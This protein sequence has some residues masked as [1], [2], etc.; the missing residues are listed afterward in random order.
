[1]GST[2]ALRGSLAAGRADAYSV[3]DVR[4]VVPDAGVATAVG[5][6]RTVLAAVRPVES[7]RSDPLFQCSRRHRFLFVRFA[8]VPLFWRLDLEVFAESAQ[9]DPNCDLDNAV[10]SGTEWSLAESALANAVAAIKATLRQRQVVADELLARAFQRLE[11]SMPPGDQALRVAALAEAARLADRFVTELAV[12]VQRLVRRRHG[13]VEDRMARVALCM[14]RV[15]SERAGNL[16]TLVA[17]PREAADKG[18]ALVRFAETALTGLGATGDPAHDLLLGEPV[19]CPTTTALAEVARACR[20]WIGLGLYERADHRLY[21]AAVLL[22]PAGVAALHYCRIDPHWHRPRNDP[23]V[24]PKGNAVPVAVTP[25]G[26]CAFLLC[27][28]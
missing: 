4:W 11:T 19:P 18:V 8:G 20:I 2:T 12:R 28:D 24:Y 9:Q 7:L 13:N 14:H 15:Q 26:R 23:T 1:M 10:A 17:M 21:D 27:G 16:A 6:L 25:F 3:I 22:A 5:R